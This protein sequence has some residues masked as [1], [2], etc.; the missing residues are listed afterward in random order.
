MFSRMLSSAVLVCGLIGVA[1]AGNTST[2]PAPVDEQIQTSQ[3]AAQPTQESLQAMYLDYLSRKGYP[4]EVSDDGM[5]LFRKE[6]GTYVIPVPQ[7][8]KHNTYFRLIYPSF[9]QVDGTEE[10]I[11]ALEAAN[12]IT[13]DTKVGKVYLM[14]DKAWVSAEVFVPKL[15][16][17]EDVFEQCMQSIVHARTTF[18]T[19]M[20]KPSE[21]QAE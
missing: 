16:H 11:R 4:A 10:R 9:W 7:I 14:G 6:G 18:V 1:A 17:F 15:E 13:A 2:L 5:I 12:F 19:R 21:P 8:V 20:Q 3:T